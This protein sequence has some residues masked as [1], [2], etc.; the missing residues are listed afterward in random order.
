MR[1][2]YHPMSERPSGSCEVLT[3]YIDRRVVKTS[4]SAKHD[5]FNVNDH[6]TAEDAKLMRYDES[7][8]FG[9]VYE[10]EFANEMVG[11]YEVL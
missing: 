7:L 1:I 11:A 8:Y 2:K 10:S 3:T 4:Y 9:W 6:D 5:A